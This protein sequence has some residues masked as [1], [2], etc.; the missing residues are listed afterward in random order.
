MAAWEYW[1]CEKNTRRSDWKPHVGSQTKSV[2]QGKIAFNETID[3]QQI[4]APKGMS[5]EGL[6]TAGLGNIS[7]V[8]E[9][10]LVDQHTGA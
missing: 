2:T 1:L 7:Q 4:T 6:K 10:N 8:F 9:T 5:V 3:V